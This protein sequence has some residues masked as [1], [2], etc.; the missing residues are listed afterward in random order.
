MYGYLCPIKKSIPSYNYN[1]LAQ[2]MF[3]QRVSIKTFAMDVV[4]ACM[5]QDWKMH[6]DERTSESY[7]W[8]QIASTEG[9][10]KKERKKKQMIRV[11]LSVG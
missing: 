1:T 11:D 4:T 8:S 7:A 6:N 3:L 10:K 5:L 2:K 9:K